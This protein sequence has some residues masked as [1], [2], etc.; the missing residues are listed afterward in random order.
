MLTLSHATSNED[1]GSTG[2]ALAFYG[3]DDDD[4]QLPTRL[5]VAYP[6]V[7][8]HSDRRRLKVTRTLLARRGD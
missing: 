5:R 3:V 1:E 6:H 7:R 4:R 8:A 2:F